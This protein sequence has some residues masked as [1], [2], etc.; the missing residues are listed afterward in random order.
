MLIVTM[1]I[2]TVKMTRSKLVNNKKKM[3]HRLHIDVILKKL[4]HL[5]PQMKLKRRIR[6]WL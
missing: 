5:R 6:S 2:M 3:R 4:I 1:K